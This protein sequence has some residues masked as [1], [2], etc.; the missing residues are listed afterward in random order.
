[1]YNC[2]LKNVDIISNYFK[3]ILIISIPIVHTDVNVHCYRS[4]S[5]FI[6]LICGEI[7]IY[8]IAR[9]QQSIH[10]KVSTQHERRHK[11]A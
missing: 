10:C 4:C 9:N 5:Y 7:K 6:L 3:L 2:C 11:Y 8:I 1:M